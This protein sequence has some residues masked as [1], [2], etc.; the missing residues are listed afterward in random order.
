[1]TRGKVRHVISTHRPD[2]FYGEAHSSVEHW[3]PLPRAKGRHGVQR[4][5]VR[6]NVEEDEPT[7][8]HKED[9][10]DCRERYK[11]LEVTYTPNRHQHHGEHQHV[12]PDVEV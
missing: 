9:D 5:Q 7:A 12:Q 11:I 1:M 4:R 6:Q 8:E 3:N 10:G 2:S